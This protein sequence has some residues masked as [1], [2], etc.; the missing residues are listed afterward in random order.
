[1]VSTFCV[2]P[3]FP[4]VLRRIYAFGGYDEIQRKE[5]LHVLMRLA[6]TGRAATAR[7]DTQRPVRGGGISGTGGYPRIGVGAIEQGGLCAIGID[8]RLKGMVV[9]GELDP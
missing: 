5:G 8:A 2:S 1:M 4:L 9:G 3:L 7:E 6:S